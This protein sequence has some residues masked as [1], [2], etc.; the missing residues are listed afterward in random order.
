[1]DVKDLKQRDGRGDWETGTGVPLADLG[2]CCRDCPF[3]LCPN[4]S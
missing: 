1:M 2:K 4:S 3:R